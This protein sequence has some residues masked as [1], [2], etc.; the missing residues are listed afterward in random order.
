M[1]KLEDELDKNIYQLEENHRLLDQQNYKLKKMNC[2]IKSIEEKNTLSKQ[3]LHRLNGLYY[4]LFYPI[5][6]EV[7]NNILPVRNEEIDK[8]NRNYKNFD[9]KILQLKE[10]S[11]ALGE[12]LDQDNE[13][14]EENNIKLEK[15][16]VDINSNKNMIN[17]FL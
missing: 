5:K 6:K 3:I 13:I 7:A 10:L 4:R 15:C 17:K 14:L 12:K 1:S 9:A 16:L 2:N 8:M 11:N